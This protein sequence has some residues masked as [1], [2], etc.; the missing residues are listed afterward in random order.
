MQAA[1]LAASLPSLDTQNELRRLRVAQLEPRLHG[2]EGVRILRRRDDARATGETFWHVPI[3]IDSAAFG[4]ASTE[5]I[6]ALLSQ[7]TGLYLEPVGAPIPQHP[8]YRPQLYRR[9]PA[10]HV[11]RLRAKRAGL[12]YA[13][14]LSS[15][16]FT[17]PHHALLASTTLLDSFADRFEALQA[18]LQAHRADAP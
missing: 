2:I 5:R 15:T 11:D 8:L 1:I 13:E 10:D 6:R 4:G 9:F 16:C 12:P 3:Q 7:S 14:R 18:E 17:L